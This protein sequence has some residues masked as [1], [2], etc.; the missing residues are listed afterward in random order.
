MKVTVMLLGLG[1]LLGCAGPDTLEERAARGDVE[2][3]VTLGSM[4]SSG[5]GVPEDDREAV[6]WFRLAADQGYARAQFYLACMYGGG[7]GVSADSGEAARWYRKAADQ[8]MAE[9]QFYLALMYEEGR[10]VPEDDEEARRWMR[11]A[12]EQ[13]LVEAA[14]YEP[15]IGRP[16]TPEEVEAGRRFGELLEAAEL[17]QVQ[18]GD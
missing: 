18:Q 16:V 12:A 14:E 2:A 10:G 17:Q 5:E 3:Q 13:G 11:L 4:Y 1:S 7:F 15:H 8:G 6:R 9:A